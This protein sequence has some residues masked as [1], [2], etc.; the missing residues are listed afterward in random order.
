M[1]MN[2]VH[3]YGKSNTNCTMFQIYKFSGV[4]KYQKVK[5]K[6]NHKML[7]IDAFSHT[8]YDHVNKGRF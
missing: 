8:V 2:I 1:Y 5:F 7:N 6:T 3:V 4:K